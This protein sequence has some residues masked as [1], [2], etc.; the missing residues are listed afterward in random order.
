MATQLEI[1]T[2]ALAGRD[3][4]IMYYQININNYT[5][6]IASL[7]GTTDPDM[8]EYKAHLENLLASETREQ[9]KVKVIR[10][11]LQA[12]VDALPLPL[13]Q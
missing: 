8:I 5:M 7:E 2:A 11:A 9:K 12:Q 4:E 1:L 3:E 6:A 10:D 13:P